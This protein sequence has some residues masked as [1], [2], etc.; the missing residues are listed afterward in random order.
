[1]I[2]QIISSMSPTAGQKD[3]LFVSENFG[4]GHTR[5]AE[6]LASGIE[7]LAPSV[8]INLV[9]L[10]REL[11][12]QIN[13]ALLHSY[14]GMIR[15]APGLWRRVYGRH[16]ARSFP[17]WIE[18]CL[19]Q[20]LYSRLS[21][22]I[23]DSPPRVVVS[24]HPF[25][26]SAI[27]RLKRDGISLSLCT[28]IT[29]FAAHGSWIYAETDLYLAPHDGVK[30]QLLEMG[31]N[32]ERVV[33]TGIPSDGQFWKKGDSEAIRRR[34]GLQPMPTVLVLGGGLGLGPTENLVRMAARWR[35]HLQI[36][37]CTGH[38][39]R[40]HASL[41]QCTELDHRH[42]RITGYT[43]EMPDWMDAA[44][45]ILS[46]AGGLTC[47]EAIAKGKPLL[48][49][50]SI[51][52]QEERNGRFMTQQ[53]MAVRVSNEKELDEWFHRLLIGDKQY[54]QLKEQMLAWRWKIHPS[55]SIRE[56]L[57]LL[58]LSIIDEGR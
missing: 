7:E 58:K 40:L 54:E 29:D 47:T 23:A 16:H 35:E 27:A 30:Q 34:L 43:E 41:S 5:A 28:V 31:V 10:G 25:A 15:R 1:M 4:T 32:P 46:K 38:N 45:V 14:M 26:S 21:E 18:W 57:G 6:A 39:H 17:R 36:V 13:Q 9:E 24:T 20:I 44:D 2:D 56:V 55:Q 48:L 19:N 11:R 53:G 3:I 42:I 37:V 22:Y 49:F 52:G 51:P 8:Q 33:V 50:G 12:P